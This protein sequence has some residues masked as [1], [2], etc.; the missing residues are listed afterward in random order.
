MTQ[1]LTTLNEDVEDEAAAVNNMLQVFENMVEVKP[2][3]GA[4]RGVLT[5]RSD[6]GQVVIWPLKLFHFIRRYDGAAVLS[7]RPGGG[8][9][10]RIG[11][12]GYLNWSFRK[13]SL[14][15]CAPTVETI[16]VLA[17][18]HRRRYRVLGV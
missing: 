2:E 7:A 10:T 11:R 18:T 15:H 4:P 14:S 6:D 16:A 8:H 3:V 5:S 12:V 13:R 9:R 17:N 1:R